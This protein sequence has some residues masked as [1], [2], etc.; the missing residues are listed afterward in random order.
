MHKSLIFDNSNLSVIQLSD[1]R[2][3]FG[4]KILHLVLMLEMPTKKTQNANK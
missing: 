1:A 4:G 2:S 3:S